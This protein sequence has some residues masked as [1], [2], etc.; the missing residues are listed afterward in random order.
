MMKCN[1]YSAK[2]RPESDTAEVQS[3]R[4]NDSQNKASFLQTLAHSLDDNEDTS[5][6]IDG[7]LAQIVNKRWGKKLG[8]I[9]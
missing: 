5:E 8:L 9:T 4:T 7:E 2:N 6:A 1:P 3:R